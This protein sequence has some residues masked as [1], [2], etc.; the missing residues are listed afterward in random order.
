MNLSKLNTLTTGKVNTTGVS[1]FQELEMDL[2]YVNAFQPRKF[3]D[4]TKIEELKNSILI[5]GLIQ[6][7]AVVKDGSGKYM[8]ISGE[9]RYRASKLANLKTIK[10]N[11]LSVDSKSVEEISLVENIQRSDL[12]D[13]E[14]ANYITSLWESGLYP[15]KQD[16]ANALGKAPAYISKALGLVKL[17]DS[18]KE[19]LSNSTTN[20]GLSVLEE[21]SRVEDKELQKEVYEKV[22]NK[23]ITRSEI[24]TF[25]GESK[26]ILK[27]KIFTGV[28]FG[29]VNH[30]GTYVGIIEGDFKGTFEFEEG[31][32][33]MKTTNN[34]E[35]K[36]TIEEL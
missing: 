28:G 7:I 5:H 8:I 12:T 18:I 29:T 21:V 35:Y 16:L 1:A 10:A 25:T 14:I 27:K 23:E 20:I 2:I 24:K 15:K 34:K 31:G 6:P 3:F 33:F 19:D 17:D 11:I 26:T 9:R 13:F 30:I 36:I 32:E 4:E 22:K